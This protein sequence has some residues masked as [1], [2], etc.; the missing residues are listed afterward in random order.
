[1]PYQWIEPEIF[2]EHENVAVYHCYDDLDNVSSYWYTTDP[3]DCN[4]KHPESNAQFDVR[5][6]PTLGLDAN[7]QSNH[8]A[9]IQHA[10]TE[11]LITGEPAITTEPP[12]VVRIE[13]QGGVAEVI[14]KPSDVEVEI[15]DHD[16][17]DE[18]D[19][20]SPDMTKAPGLET[21]MQWESEDGC[22]ATD[23]CWVE[24]DGI[25]SHG[26]KSWLLVLGLI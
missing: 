20:C 25:C 10:I 12:K 1:M 21:L 17:V 5:D 14:E 4:Y 11:G 19:L 23:G 6:L 8:A 13:M 24:P 22:E 26:C 2:L 7:D 16:M 15:I 9:I 3:S 18:R